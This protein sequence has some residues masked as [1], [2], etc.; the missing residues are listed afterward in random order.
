MI[1]RYFLAGALASVAVPSQAKTSPDLLVWRDA[2]ADERTPGVTVVRDGEAW[3]DLWRRTVRAAPPRP[4]LPDHVGVAIRLG[5]RRTGGYGIEILG[6]DKRACADY[7]VYK[8]HA[9][10]PG[11]YVT[12]A[13]TSPWTIALIPAGERPVVF[14]REE[15]DGARRLVIPASEGPRLAQSGE[16]CRAL[17]KQ[18]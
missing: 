12:Q 5:P 6:H 2:Y 3:A 17:S 1:R 16:A 15:R 11:A 8:E 9:P 13:F 10:E 7:V 18:P 4:L 14:E